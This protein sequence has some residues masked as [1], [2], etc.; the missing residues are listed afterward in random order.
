MSNNDKKMLP[1]YITSDKMGVYSHK[2]M[3]VNKDR[4]LEFS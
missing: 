3:K 1:I 2:V 4:N